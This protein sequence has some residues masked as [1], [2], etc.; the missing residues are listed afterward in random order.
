MKE[1]LTYLTYLITSYIVMDLGIKDSAI[2]ILVAL[3]AFII[4]RK[5]TK[6]IEE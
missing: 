4:F 5:I 6:W 1:Q 2:C 3:T